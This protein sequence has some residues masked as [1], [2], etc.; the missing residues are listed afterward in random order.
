MQWPVT[1]VKVSWEKHS[2]QELFSYASLA[3]SMALDF[4]V[5]YSI[6]TW[7]LGQSKVVSWVLAASFLQGRGYQA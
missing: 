5:L 4:G 2:E 3:A 6:G 7:M 1:E